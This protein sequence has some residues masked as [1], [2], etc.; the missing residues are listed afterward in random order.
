MENGRVH[1]NEN[2]F[3]GIGFGVFAVALAGVLDEFVSSCSLDCDDTV[4]GSSGF[5]EGL[6]ANALGRT[7]VHDVGKVTIHEVA[8]RSDDETTNGLLDTSWNEGSEVT[9]GMLVESLNV[10]DRNVGLAVGQLADVELGTFGGRRFDLEKSL[11]LGTRSEE[12]ARGAAD[13]GLIRGRSTVASGSAAWRRGDVAVVGR[14]GGNNCDFRV[15]F[16][17]ADLNLRIFVRESEY[18]ILEQKS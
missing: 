1:G 18:R 15:E 5:E 4:T 9:G 3:D 6:G 8:S 10:V 2:A 14:H 16:F 12:F 17:C 13:T 11:T 7:S